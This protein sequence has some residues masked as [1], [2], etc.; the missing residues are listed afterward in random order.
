[1]SFSSNASQWNATSNV[2]TWNPTIGVPTSTNVSQMPT[3]EFQQ[4]LIPLIGAVGA[5]LLFIAMLVVWRRSRN[6][7][8]T[9]HDVEAQQ[10]LIRN[11]H[12][13]NLNGMKRGDMEDIGLEMTKWACGICG[14]HNIESKKSCTLCETSRGITIHATDT[15]PPGSSTITSAKL[16][17]EQHAAWARKMWLRSLPTDADATSVWNVSAPF[18][19][20]T[21]F[22]LIVAPPRALP[23][24]DV[25]DAL[26]KNDTSDAH[27][28]ADADEATD[29][30]VVA[31]IAPA[32]PRLPLTL[33][34]L[35]PGVTAATSCVSGDSLP[36]WYLP[37]LTT[38]QE[39]PFSL[40]YAW[41]LEQIAASYDGRSGFTVARDQVLDQ[42]LT[43]LM[44]LAPHELCRTTRVTMAGE[45]AL[46]AGGVQREWYTV[47]ANAV[48]ASGLFM[49]TNATDHVYMVHPGAT[50]AS[51]LDQFEAIGRLLGKAI[52]DG[53][54]LPLRLCVPLFKA[55]LGTPL[56]IEDVRYLDETTY[57]SLRF[58]ETTEAVEELALDFS[59]L[60]P[61]ASSTSASAELLVVDLIENGRN[62]DVTEANKAQYV[63]SMV[64]HLVFGRWALQVSRLVDGFYEV[65]P[66]ELVAPLDYKE[67]ELVL[68]GTTEIDVSD[69]REHTIV[70]RSLQCSNAL[71][72]F[73]D[74]VEFDMSPEEHAKFLHFTTGSS[75]VPLQGFKGL[76]SY[77][78]KLCLFT[79]Q[80][81]TYTR[82]CLPKV[83][84]C[85]NRIDLPLYPSRGL[86]KDALFALVRMESMAFTL[87]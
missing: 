62:V 58:I 76:T 34:P 40:K 87:E 2:S 14:F 65:L 15:F 61:V 51:D 20:S 80:A 36:T 84:T 8:P 47:L 19:L 11:D 32:A 17:L 60:A 63:A 26:N 74:I 37:Q 6:R 23:D 16:N 69:W 73:W 72:W 18:N 9:A 42:S 54:V 46:D 30:S 35:I 10:E 39:L 5:G 78:G 1:M 55:L 28:A 25:Q 52:I 41:L 71:E 57:N 59:V 85:F 4:I 31:D 22:Y 49:P 27:D 56:S 66:I 21:Q 7:A 75:R 53:Q 70:S 44:Q 33:E 79:L 83:H 48:M 82:G 45:D 29:S 81:I 86:M 64:Q 12:L 67:L 50:S 68:C 13:G 3:P 24:T 38:L 43:F 77:D